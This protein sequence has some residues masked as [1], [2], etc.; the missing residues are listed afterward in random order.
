MALISLRQML[1]HAAEYEYGVPAFNVNN[2]EQMRAIMM[3]ADKTDKPRYCAGVRRGTEI[4]RR[5]LSA[6]YDTRCY[7]RV[8][9]YS[10]VHAS[11]S[12]D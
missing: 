5:T 10:S 3:A 9:A 1:D 11:G 8:A 2:V 7:R 6:P 4:C 12:W